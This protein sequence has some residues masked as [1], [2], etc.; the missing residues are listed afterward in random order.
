MVSDFSRIGAY[1]VPKSTTSG[2]SY[3][4]GSSSSFSSGGGFSG[5]GFSGGGSSS[6]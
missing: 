4:S 3:R 1:A 2:G 6:W 5:G